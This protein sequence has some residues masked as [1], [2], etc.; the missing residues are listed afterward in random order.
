[1]IP[2]GDPELAAYLHEH[3]RTIKPER[4]NKIFWF[5]TP[6]NPGKPVD[7]TPI[8]TQFFREI[9]ELK[10]K[11]KLNP[12]ESTKYRTK[13]LER[14]DWTD[15]FLTETEI[16]ATEAILVEDHDIFARHR[17]DSGINT[18]FKVKLTPKDDKAV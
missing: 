3:L 13:L 9:T 7:H 17:M 16:Q 18:E 12:Q 6:E 4:Q 10:E 11:E 2:Q 5:P 15:T 14:F 1:M 8:Q